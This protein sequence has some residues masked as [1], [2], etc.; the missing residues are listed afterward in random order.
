MPDDIMFFDCRVMKLDTP[1]WDR[2]RA[3]GQANKID[4][5]GSSATL[6][7]IAGTMLTVLCEEHYQDK[8]FC[9]LVVLTY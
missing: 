2:R 5:A 8:S 7:E 4:H 1:I 6:W 9:D 3:S